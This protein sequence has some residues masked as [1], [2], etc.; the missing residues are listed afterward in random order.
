LK[1]PGRPAQGK[2]LGHAKTKAHTPKPARP[3]KARP[4]RT[5]AEPKAPKTKAVNGAPAKAPKG[6]SAF[7]APDAPEAATPGPA[8]AP[9]QSAPAPPGQAKKQD[10]TA[11]KP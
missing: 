6:S 11:K 3:V 9:G 8:N 7:K 1:A 2:A 10:E 5:L 4:D